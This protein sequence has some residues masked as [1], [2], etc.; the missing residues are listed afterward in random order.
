MLSDGSRRWA[1]VEGGEGTL[2][3]CGC[4]KVKEVTVDRWF[5]LLFGP[6]PLEEHLNH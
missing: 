1:G 5:W 2:Q 6:P 4:C 3:K